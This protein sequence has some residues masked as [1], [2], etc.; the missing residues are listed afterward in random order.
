MKKLISFILILLISAPALAAVN[1]EVDRST[2]YDGDSFQLT[3]STDKQS[4]SRPDTSPL[5][6]DFEILGTASGSS[7]NII[8]GKTTAKTTWTITLRPRVMG[9]LKIPPLQVGGENTQTLTIRVLEPPENANNYQDI[10]IETE[11]SKSNPYVQEM[12]TYTVRIYLAAELTEGSLNTPAINNAVV[13]RLGEDRT[14][15]VNRN[16]RNYQVITRR[17]AIFPQSSG[18]IELPPPVLDGKVPD[19]RQQNANPNNPFANDPFFNND[20]FFGN[21]RFNKFF[22]STRP[23]RVRGKAR[24]LSVL[25]PPDSASSSHWLPTPQLL[26]TEQWDIPDELHVGAP[27]TRTIILRARN[28]MASQLPRIEAPTL[29]N[30]GVYADKAV[31]NTSDL[32]DGIESQIEQRIV[33]VPNAAGKLEIPAIQIPWWNTQTNQQE[34]ASLPAREFTIVSIP[35]ASTPSDGIVKKEVQL[36]TPRQTADEQKPSTAQTASRQKSIW[37]WIS[38]LLALIWFGTLALWWRERYTAGKQPSPAQHSS[39][40][41][42]TGNA[43][44]FRKQFIEACELNNPADARKALLAWAAQ[45]WPENPPR[46]IEDLAKRLQDQKT[47]DQLKELDAAVYAERGNNWQGKAL[48]ESL[49]QLP[50]DKTDNKKE[51]PLPALFPTTGK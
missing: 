12:V 18:K 44:R 39:R 24:E 29:P 40:D 34:T 16:G 51:K 45:H 4:A 47:K 26:M 8:N 9:L 25:P 27:I 1:A 35:G 15:N 43:S 33:Y 19:T 5:L 22:A 38:G 3:I 36:G 6:Q 48:S 20:P 14:A 7:I 11:V 49:K 2:V 13:E 30:A 42:P 10:F 41:N 37:P 23:I 46:G 32:P 50:P 21:P 31:E 28:L 17:Y